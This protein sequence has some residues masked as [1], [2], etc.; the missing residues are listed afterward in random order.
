MR[1]TDFYVAA[2]DSP[3]IARDYLMI[4]LLD[5]LRQQGIL[6]LPLSPLPQG[7]VS[8]PNG[9][10]M[11]APLALYASDADPEESRRITLAMLDAE[12]VGSSLELEHWDASLVWYGRCRLAGSG[13]SDMSITFCGRCATSRKAR[14]EPRRGRVR[15][16]V[17]RS[18]QLSGVQSG[19]CRPPPG[20]QLLHLQFGC[21]WA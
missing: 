16:R 7:R 18:R 20:S 11:P 19:I 12:W 2:A 17:R 5:L 10:G 8:P 15:G 4:D 9:D 1:I 13:P 3:R 21:H 6:P 14:A